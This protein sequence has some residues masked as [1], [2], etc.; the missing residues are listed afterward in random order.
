MPKL[1]SV[2]EKINWERQFRARGEGRRPTREDRLD[3]F[4][5]LELLPIRHRNRATARRCKALDGG[6]R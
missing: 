5:D 1:I 2:S 4:A 6:R 3:D